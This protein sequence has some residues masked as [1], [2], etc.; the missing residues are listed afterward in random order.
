MKET[1][2]LKRTEPLSAELE[3][4]LRTVIV[5]CRGPRTEEAGELVGELLAAGKLEEARLADI[6]G[7]TPCGYDTFKL[8]MEY[9]LDGE[10]HS[11]PCPGCGV[12]Q[13]WRPPALEVNAA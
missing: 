8:V 11:H 7:R 13:T 2:E 1:D 4:Q 6:E 5:R 3:E 9:P 10:P 12:M